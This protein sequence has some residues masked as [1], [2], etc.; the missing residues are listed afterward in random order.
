MKATVRVPHGLLLRMLDSHPVASS[1]PN[2]KLRIH[3]AEQSVSVG[4]P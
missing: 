4:D 3:V 1:T 2:S